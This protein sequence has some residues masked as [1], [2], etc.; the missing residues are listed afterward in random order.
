MTPCHIMIVPRPQKDSLCVDDSIGRRLVGGHSPCWC[1]ECRDFSPK[2]K[3]LLINEILFSLGLARARSHPNEQLGLPSSSCCGVQALVTCHCV[4]VS[5][6]STT[7]LDS[8]IGRPRSRGDDGRRSNK[9]AAG[10]RSQAELEMPAK[11]GWQNFE[12]IIDRRPA[13]LILLDVSS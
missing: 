3:V 5:L 2:H 7:R 1:N 9:W 13:A 12:C 8:V 6:D 4:T 10:R 11:G